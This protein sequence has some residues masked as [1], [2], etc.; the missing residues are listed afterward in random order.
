MSNLKRFCRLS[1][2]DRWLTIEA[3][4]CLGLAR[5]AVRT[6]P[7]RWVARGLTRLVRPGKLAPKGAS[8]PSPEVWHVARAIQRVS[9]RTPWRSNCL[10]QA[11]AG[12]WM[13]GR[14]GA[15]PSLYLGVGKN[16]RHEFDA[17]AWLQVG[18]TTILGHA[19]EGRYAVVG[20][21]A[22]RVASDS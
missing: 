20:V 16:D 15:S 22:D 12:H 5:G 11:I 6:L 8:R 1:P 19:A 10:A 4:V 2:H 17:H 13:L 21:F 3:L 7:F 14:R 18:G 9:P